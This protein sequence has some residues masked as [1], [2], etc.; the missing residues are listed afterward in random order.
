MKYSENRIFAAKT[1]ESSEKIDGYFSCL[2]RKFV[3]P[4]INRIFQNINEFK[5]A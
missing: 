4:R 1:L 2:G 3:T 5:P